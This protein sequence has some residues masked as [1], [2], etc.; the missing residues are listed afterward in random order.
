MP[1]REARFNALLDVAEASLPPAFTAVDLGCGPGPLSIRLLRRFPRARC[2]AVDHDPVVLRIGEGSWGSFGGRLRWVDADLG[3]GSWRELLPFRRF[4]LA[5]S[6][7]ALHWLPAPRLGT[8]Y[9][10]LGRALRPGGVF[11]NGDHLPWGPA[12]PALDR[13]A[14]RVRR[15]RWRGRRDVDTWAP[16]REFWASAERDPELGA[17]FPERRRRHSQ[18]PRHGDAPLGAHTRALRRAGFGT[19]EVLWRDL[20][21][22]ILYARRGPR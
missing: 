21:N 18:H 14:D 1:T 4:D 7:T 16:W 12:S 22:G 3:R 20:A 17:L 6:T 10:E 19:V 8:C 9:R 2:V 11:L 5:V 15:V 13:L